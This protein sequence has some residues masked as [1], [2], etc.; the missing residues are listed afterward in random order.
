MDKNIL[1]EYAE[2]LLSAALCRTHNT[3]DAEDLVSETL[4]AALEYSGGRPIDEPKAWLMT[5]LSRRHCD[6]LRRK[7]RRP[8]VSFDVA[9]DIPT[10]SQVWEELERK[11]AEEN[12]RRCLGSLV[13]TYRQVMVRYYMHNESVREISQALGISESAVKSRLDTGRKHIRKEYDMKNFT[14]QSYAPEYL[15][16]ASSGRH[17][18][19][20]EPFC[21]VN[22]R[23][24]EMN[25]LILAY[26]KSLTIPELS[27]AIGISTAYIEPVVDSLVEG[28]LMK[29]VSD[30]IYTDFIIYSEEDRTANLER[31]RE[32]ADKCSE[33][34]YEI[35]SEGL[36]ELKDCG[37]Y[38]AQS[39]SKGLKLESFFWVR[40]VQNAV[41]NVRNKYAGSPCFDSYPD[42][43]NCGKWYAM[44][45]R[46]PAGYDWSGEYHR[47][48]ISGESVETIEDYCGLSLLTN[49]EYDCALGK[50]HSAYHNL[51]YKMSGT[52]IL[53]MLY[54]VHSHNED[55]L[56]VINN[57]CF[58]NI[59]RL[60]ELGLLVRNADG[61]IEC[62]VPVI[63][64]CDRWEL[65]ELSE[66]Y[67]NIISK[68]FEAEFGQLMD[69]PVILPS[70]LK[71]VPEWLRY[72][73]CCSS[74]PMM[75]IMNIHK[76]GKLFGERDLNK[77]PVPPIFIAIE[78]G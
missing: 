63:N 39:Y 54:A 23:P 1:N 42:R 70:H 11:E 26:K 68:R 71:S 30:R 74:L 53:K 59:D 49:C 52:E 17:G 22:S 45:N 51:P 77:S 73:W 60:T 18:L 36:K 33:G 15:S 9:E 35:M 27:K 19:N 75:I 10:P 8:Y 5:I 66:K 12:I 62:N 24:I 6:R 46:F 29:R 37:Y 32:I 16:I 57:R 4:L 50:T 69:N 78:R 28:E 48:P 58:D 21:L 44:G 40:T 64:M 3:A 13:K 7:Y 67:D 65:Y 14:E 2:F 41:N 20:N 55:I 56:P 47:Y 72:M 31:E 43:K 76:N 61:H 34:V 25:L 38:K